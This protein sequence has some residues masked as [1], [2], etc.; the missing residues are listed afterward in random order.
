MTVVAA[1]TL[2]GGTAALAESLAATNANTNFPN[3]ELVIAKAKAGSAKDQTTLGDYYLSKSDFTN[4]VTWYR[5]AAEHG[6]PEAMLSLASCYMTG[7]GVEKSEQESTRWLRQAA[8]RMGDSL[9]DAP[10]TAAAVAPPLATDTTSVAAAEGPVTRTRCER[11]HVLQRID[12]AIV[13][14][15]PAIRPA[16]AD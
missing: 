12:P 2:S 5:T 15:A 8:N 14:I 13:Q 10:K 6:D 16:S 11:V 3:V 4:A 9:E 1:Y 7:R